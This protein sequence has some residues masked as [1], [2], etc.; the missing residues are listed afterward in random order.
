MHPHPPPP[1]LTVAFHPHDGATLSCQL[2]QSYAYQKFRRKLARTWNRYVP[3]DDD[4]QREA[5]EDNIHPGLWGATAA[6]SVGGTWLRAVPRDRA[7]SSHVWW[8]SIHVSPVATTDTSNSPCDASCCAADQ[9][10]RQPCAC[11]QEFQTPAEAQKETDILFLSS[12]LPL[13]L[14]QHRRPICRL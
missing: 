2:Q 12:Q 9:C 3:T 7:M 11:S 10:R 1:G 4:R 14:L 5:L 6:Q 8:S 13:L